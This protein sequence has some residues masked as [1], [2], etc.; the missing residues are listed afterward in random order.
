MA[1]FTDGVIS[2]LEDLRDYESAVFTVANSES[3]NLTKKLA[4]AQQEI[5]VEITAFLLQR[6]EET[7]A[8]FVTS[9]PDLTT[10]VVTPSLRQWH[11]FHTLTLVYRDAYNSH[12]NDRYLGKWKEYERLARWAEARS[13]ETGIGILKDPIGKASPPKLSTVEGGLPA[14]TYWVRVAWTGASG[15]GGA[16]E[17]SVLTTPANSQL[18]AEVSEAPANASGWNVYVG[19]SAV[20]VRLQNTAPLELLASWTMPESGLQHGRL[21]GDGQ[22]P[23]YYLTRKRTLQ[24]G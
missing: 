24:R 21:A 12:F 6:S 13:F 20:E 22:T 3:M 2:E 11:T 4:L 23:D 18:A 7:A 9:R 14:T 15:E 5:E 10:V 17:P 19:T 1:L 8:G 16:S